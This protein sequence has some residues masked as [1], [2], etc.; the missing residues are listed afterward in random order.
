MSY[1]YPNFRLQIFIPVCLLQKIILIIYTRLAEI[2]FCG[3]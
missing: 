2:A 1:D 3:S